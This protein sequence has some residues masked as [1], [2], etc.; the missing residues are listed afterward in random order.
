MPGRLIQSM[1]LGW[2]DDGRC[3]ATRNG[4]C[5]LIMEADAEPFTTAEA[6]GRVE[7]IPKVGPVAV[8][9]EDDAVS[10]V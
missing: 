2:S 1:E 6:F 8:F 4:Y 7:L 9:V 3:T 5:L 10:F